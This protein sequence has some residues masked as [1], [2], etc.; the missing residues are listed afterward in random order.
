VGPLAASAAWLD[1]HRDQDVT[2]TDAVSFEVMRRQRIRQAFAF[3]THFLTA[4]FE[5]LS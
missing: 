4:G 1:R 2:L 3:D 5:F